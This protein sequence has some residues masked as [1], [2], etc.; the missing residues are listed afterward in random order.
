LSALAEII[1]IPTTKVARANWRAQQW[2]LRKRQWRA[3]EE[4]RRGLLSWAE[5]RSV[6]EEE[7]LPGPARTCQWIEH[8]C[9]CNERSVLGKSWCAVHCARVFAAEEVD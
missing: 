7:G 9:F 1:C 5:L 3:E 6:P 4:V 2:R 8:G